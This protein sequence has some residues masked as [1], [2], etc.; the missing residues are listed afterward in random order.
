MF[1]L[2]LAATIAIPTSF[3]PQHVTIISANSVGGSFCN[4]CDVIQSPRV[5]E[6]SV[7]ADLDPAVDCHYARSFWKCKDGWIERSWVDALMNAVRRPNRHT[8][9]EAG[10]STSLISATVHQVRVAIRDTD[11]WS[12]SEKAGL[13][14]AASR[15][16]IEGML[17]GAE[18]LS[19]TYAYQIVRVR[20]SDARGRTIVIESKYGEPK[21]LPWLVSFGRAS[22]Y[23]AS[24]AISDA[25]ARLLPSDSISRTRLL[26]PH[27]SDSSELYSVLRRRVTMCRYDEDPNDRAFCATLHDRRKP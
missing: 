15:R 21:M 26:A 5:L 13:L 14:R 17:F 22:A 10:Y 3:Q 24:A 18:R 2:L 27:Q 19:P 12:A 1:A 25:I 16:G 20:L 9:Q 4:G 7:I 8:A 11:D 6:P 23:V